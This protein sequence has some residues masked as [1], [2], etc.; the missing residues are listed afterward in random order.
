MF[1]GLSPVSDAKSGEEV[2]P[3]DS[4]F[5]L[6]PPKPPTP[7]ESRDTIGNIILPPGSN[8]PP[9]QDPTEKSDEDIAKL[10][11]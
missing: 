7:Q 10:W 3:K 4:D 1:K 9:V 6:N 5:V 2:K 8:P 11:K